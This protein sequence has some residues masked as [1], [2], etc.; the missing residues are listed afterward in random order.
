MFMF[1]EINDYMEL[2]KRKLGANFEENIVEFG[3]DNNLSH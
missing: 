2:L 1:F 3:K